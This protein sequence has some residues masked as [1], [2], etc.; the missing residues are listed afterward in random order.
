MRRANLRRYNKGAPEG[1]TGE[2]VIAVNPATLV[3]R[4]LANVGS[5]VA[6]ER[7]AAPVWPA[8]Y[9]PADIARQSSTRIANPSYYVT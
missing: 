7:S 3:H 1:A 4:A 5:G 2:L 9:C 6:S 8:R